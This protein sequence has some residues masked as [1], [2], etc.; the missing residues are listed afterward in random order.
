MASSE[1]SD[2]PGE[3]LTETEREALH[4]LELGLECLLRA[5]GHL[6]EFHHAT[7]RGMDHVAVA[8]DLLRESGHDELAD[9]I[10]DGHLPSGVTDDDRWSYAV[11]EGFQSGLLADAK[12]FEER[13]RREVA[14]GQRHVTERRQER[15]WR[16]RA[17]K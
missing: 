4:E 1:R 10:R 13:A 11:L 6:I 14:D 16:D 12:A 5:Q 3:T 15:E 7:G 2:R 9:E 8:E 17:R